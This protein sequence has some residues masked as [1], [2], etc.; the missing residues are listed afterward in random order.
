MSTGLVLDPLFQKHETDLD[1]PESPERLVAV[2]DALAA[3]GLIERTVPVPLREATR[4][5]LTRV[6]SPTYVEAVLAMIRDGARYLAGGDVSVCRASGDVARTATGSLLEAVD[7]VMTG[8]ITNAF[9]ALRPPGHHAT[10]TQ[11]MG[12]CIFNHAAAAARHAQVVHGAERVAI[13]DWDVHHGNGTQDIFYEDGTV[14]FCSTHQSP[15]YPG[16]GSASESGEGAGAGTTIN[17]PFPAGAGREEILGAFTDV[18]LPA[19]ETFRPDLIVISAGFDSR[20]GDPLGRFRLTDEDFADLTRAVMD[21]AGR[22]CG[23]RIVSTLE[24]GYNV[25][26]FASAVSTHVAALAA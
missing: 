1:H 23:G 8:K 9:C 21:S 13:L 22:M 14:L 19:V 3:A 5:E 7:L 11:A 6:H 4:D 26:G 2:A 24:G 12:F 10:A 17:R 16:S 20:A 15:W 18:F 25:P